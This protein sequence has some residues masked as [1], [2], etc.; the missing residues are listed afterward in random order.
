MVPRR[1]NRRMWE[2]N[3][4]SHAMRLRYSL[5]VLALLVAAPAGAQ[6]VVNSTADVAANDGQCTLREAIVASNTDLPSGTMTGECAAGSGEDT[7]TLDVPVGSTITLTADLPT[8]TQTWTLEGPTGEA[9]GVTVDGDGQFRIFELDSNNLG[10]THTLRGLTVTGGLATAGGGILVGFQENC[11]FEDIA[12]VGNVATNGAG[13]IYTGREG[14]CTMNRV[15]V[16]DNEAQG[17]SGAG[18]IRISGGGDFVIRNSTIANNRATA[19][20]AGG[21]LVGFFQAPQATFLLEQSTVSGNEAAGSGGGISQIGSNGSSVIRAT[22]IVDNHIT[23]APSAGGGVSFDWDVTFESTVIAGNTAERGAGEW[24]DLS[25][26]VNRTTS[27]GGNVIGIN[28]LF[29]SEFPLGTP[30]A[31]GDLVGNE[32]APVDPLLEALADNGGPMPTRIPMATSPVIDAGVCPGSPA[33][34]RGSVREVDDPAFL[35]LNGDA[36]DSGAVEGRTFVVGT[37]RDPIAGVSLHAPVP[38]PTAGSAR[39]TFSLDASGPV[40]LSLLDVRGREVALLVDGQR[41]A[42]EHEEAL[43][44]LAPGVYLVKLQAGAGVLSQR[45]TVV[46]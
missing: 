20:G 45:V 37:E 15:Y 44:S 6:I 3:P 19:T 14:S 8:A 4:N 33:D 38:N 23:G 29:D 27:N 26:G 39:L 41:P 40:R 2:A 35:D 31:N 43:P 9:D 5:L 32:G 12:V 24:N 21:I 17:A 18:G 22:T 28:G 25:L 10:Q 7:V 16:A 1:G 13:G 36:C 30:N 46:R 34:Q 11:D 42:G